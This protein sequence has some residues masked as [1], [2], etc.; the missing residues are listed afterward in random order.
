MLIVLGY[1]ARIEAMPSC[2]HYGEALGAGSSLP[3]SPEKTFW[4]IKWTDLITPQPQQCWIRVTSVTYTTACGNIR[5]LLRPE[6]KFASLCT[7]C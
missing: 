6:I 3:G 2:S 4:V 1:Y 7:L 5:P